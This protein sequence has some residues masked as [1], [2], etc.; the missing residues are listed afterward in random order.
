MRV[1]KLFPP[2]NISIAVCAPRLN[3]LIH[4]A[5]VMEACVFFSL[6]N[7]HFVFWQRNE[8]QLYI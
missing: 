1:F 3:E 8:L 2:P 6:D 4:F 5:L 7:N